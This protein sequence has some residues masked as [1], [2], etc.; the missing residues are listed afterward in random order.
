MKFFHLVPT[1]INFSLKISFNFII[2][3]NLNLSLVEDKMSGVSYD[4]VNHIFSQNEKLSI[5][6]R[7]LKINLFSLSQ[8]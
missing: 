3:L 5:I 8:I 7:S 4:F 1:K 6:F 2:K